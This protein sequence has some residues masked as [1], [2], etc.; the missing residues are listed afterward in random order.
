[1]VTSNVTGIGRGLRAPRLKTAPRGWGC[2]RCVDEGAL[3]VR[4]AMALPAQR[5]RRRNGD[6]GACDALAPIITAIT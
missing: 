5:R 2:Q 4:P 3:A 6:D 1:M